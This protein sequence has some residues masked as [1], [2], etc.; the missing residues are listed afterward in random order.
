MT[1]RELI[2]YLEGYDEE[3]EVVM[4]GANSG[5]YV[6]SISDFDERELRSFYGNNRDVLVILARSQVG[7][8]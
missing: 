3:M 7:M 6:D 8:V 2:D 4:K 1:V 5:G